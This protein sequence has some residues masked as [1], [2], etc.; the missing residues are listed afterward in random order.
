MVT[1]AVGVLWGAWACQTSFTL[2]FPAD[3][4]LG[5]LSVIEDANCFTCGTGTKRVGN[6]TGSIQ[7]RRPADHWYV[8][9]EPPDQISSL[10][11]HFRDSSLSEINSLDLRDSD[12]QDEDLGHLTNLKLERIDLSGT[13]ITGKGLQ[14]LTPHQ[15]FWLNIENTR[16]HLTFAI[17]IN[18]YL[19]SSINEPP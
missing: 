5:E 17:S 7:I 19:G 12:V 11:F 16:E 1:S 4:S 14:Y 3:T 9:L 18:A 15:F 6:A 8:H 13:T 2:N 10:M